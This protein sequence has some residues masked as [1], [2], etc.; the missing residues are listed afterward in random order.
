M[1]IAF[2][3]TYILIIGFTYLGFVLT[4]RPAMIDVCWGLG[5]LAIGSICLAFN[6]HL[7]FYNVLVYVCLVAWALRLSGFL[8]WT[9]IVSAH[10]EKR[11]H[12]LLKQPGQPLHRQFLKQIILQATLMYMLMLPFYFSLLKTMHSH[13]FIIH[14][15]QMLF[16]FCWINEAI[17]DWQRHRYR[18]VHHQGICRTGLWRYSRHPNYF[19]ELG[20]WYAFALM[21]MNAP[22]GWISLMSPLLL[23]ALMLLITIP[24]TEKQSLARDPMYAAYQHETAKLIPM[25]KWR[26]P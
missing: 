6:T 17:T 5:H 16:W 1:L 3:L 24:V 20:M 4:Q 26:K 22:W 23:Q 2:L 12:G 25:L 21:A 14:L 18:Q 19:F 8:F 7:T 13:G 15:S 11:Y 9:R 10:Q